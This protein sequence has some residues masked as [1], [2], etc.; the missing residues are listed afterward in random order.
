MI[1]PATRWF[2]IA[3]YDNKR[4]ITIAN[5]VEQTWFS[6]YLWPTQL[7]FDHR[8]EFMGHEF[9]QMT[10]EDYGIKEKPIMVRHKKL[11]S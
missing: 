10:S 5:K 11:T 7:R 1:D 6:Q 3:S 4:S 8:S 2:E 9:K